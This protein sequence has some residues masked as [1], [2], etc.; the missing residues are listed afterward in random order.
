MHSRARSNSPQD[1]EYT[2]GEI[3]L[4]R[5]IAELHVSQTQCR[6]RASVLP[7]YQQLTDRRGGVSGTESVFYLYLYLAGQLNSMPREG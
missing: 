1:F 5:P 7:I 2:Q 3:P 4:Q 6:V